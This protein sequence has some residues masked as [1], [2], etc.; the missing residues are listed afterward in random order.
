MLISTAIALS[1]Q[2]RSSSMKQFIGTAAAVGA[3]S[4]A[5]L[6]IVGV[7][8]AVPSGQSVADSVSTAG[9]FSDGVDFPLSR[10]TVVNVGRDLAVV[11]SARR[12]DCISVFRLN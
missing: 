7:A 12:V 3:L 2:S 6:G 9:G 11:D 4:A 10:C 8:A 1:Q 5:V